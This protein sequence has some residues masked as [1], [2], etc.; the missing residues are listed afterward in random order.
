MSKFECAGQNEVAGEFKR[1]HDSES[2]E[3]TGAC[4]P[5]T[6]SEGKVAV[7]CEVEIAEDVKS[8]V[9]SR[10]RPL[11]VARAELRSPEMS[12]EARLKLCRIK[13]AAATGPERYGRH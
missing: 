7:E 12:L 2:P 6:N 4:K 8:R 13:T 5:P 11:A 1:A 10:A 3:G 9:T